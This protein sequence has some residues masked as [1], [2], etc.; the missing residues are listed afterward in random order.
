METNCLSPKRDINMDNR[1]HLWSNI[2]VKWQLQE[3]RKSCQVKGMNGG[4][5]DWMLSEKVG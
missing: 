1:E 5:G 4:G 3:S 2:I